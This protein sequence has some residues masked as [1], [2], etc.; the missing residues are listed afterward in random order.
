MLNQVWNQIYVSSTQVSLSSNAALF[1]SLL[2]FLSCCRDLWRNI[3]GPEWAGL[4]VRSFRSITQYGLQEKG[5]ESSK[6]ITCYL[7]PERECVTRMCDRIGLVI[8][9]WR[10]FQCIVHTFSIALVKFP[11]LIYDTVWKTLDWYV[12]VFKFFVRYV[13]MTSHSIL[14]SYSCWKQ[15]T[16]LWS[17]FPERQLLFSG[18]TLRS[19]IYNHE[20]THFIYTISSITTVKSCIDKSE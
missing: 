13:N 4:C 10:F 15:T 8:R 2:V 5:G 14:N 1:N 7:Y 3:S 9:F 11:H 12:D 16:C 19:D 6:I 20:S 17:R 18:S